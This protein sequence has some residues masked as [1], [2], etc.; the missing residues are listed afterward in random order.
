MLYLS[1]TKLLEGDSLYSAIILETLKK[2]EPDL[3]NDLIN[4]DDFKNN[5][6]LY[7]RFRLENAFKFT[8]IQHKLLG[9][10]FTKDMNS[11]ILYKLSTQL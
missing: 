6:I 2:D 7:M 8:E 1:I 4:S 5:V 9:K 10:I 11:Q 3:Y